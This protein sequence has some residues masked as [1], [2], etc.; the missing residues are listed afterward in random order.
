MTLHK[1]ASHLANVSGPFEEPK[2]DTTDGLVALF[3]K[4]VTEARAAW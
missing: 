3:D 1:L 4:A 2:P